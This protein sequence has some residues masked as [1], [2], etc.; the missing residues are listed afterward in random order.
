[1]TN[2][3][4]RPRKSGNPKGRPA[5]TDT[6]MTPEVRAAFLLALERTGAW[7]AS[8]AAV[9]ISYSTMKNC[10]DRDPEFADDC[11]RALGRLEDQMMQQVKHLAL[12]GVEEPIFDRNGNEIGTR[13]KFSERVLLA[14]LRKQE[15]GSWLDKGKVKVEGSVEHQHRVQVEDLTPKQRR[16]ARD[17]L[18]DI[19]SRN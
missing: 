5:G 14:W 2:P 4:K 7:K 19:E 13:R 17:L 8:C 3:R 6:T 11:A 10:R 16:M 15:S 1:M 9:G 12:E 18:A